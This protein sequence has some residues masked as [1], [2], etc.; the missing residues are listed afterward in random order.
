MA[1]YTRVLQVFLTDDSEDLAATMKALDKEMAN[2]E[3]WALGINDLC[4]GLADPQQLFAG[5]KKAAK[6][7]ASTAKHA[8]G[9]TPA[10][11][12]DPQ[13]GP[14]IDADASQGS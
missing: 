7:A 9:R 4:D 8:A 14:V 1:L 3:R 5:F 13:K 11:Q 12:S 2:A 10:T 6:S